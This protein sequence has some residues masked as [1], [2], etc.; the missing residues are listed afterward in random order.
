MCF[1]KKSI[2]GSFVLVLGVA[3]LFER[4]K[5]NFLRKIVWKPLKMQDFE[6]PHTEVEW[7]EAVEPSEDSSS[8]GADGYN[9]SDGFCWMLG[10]PSCF[11][12][13]SS[14]S[15]SVLTSACKKMRH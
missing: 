14:S 13:S 5:V 12:S 11:V 4:F 10:D 15:S 6:I 9:L 2:V 1:E 3:A 8:N 7:A